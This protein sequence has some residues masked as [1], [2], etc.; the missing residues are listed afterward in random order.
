MRNQL[1]TFAPDG[2]EHGAIY[3]SPINQNYQ[4]QMAKSLVASMGPSNAVGFALD[5]SWD[6]VLAQIKTLVSIDGLA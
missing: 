3:K 1:N 2:H 6:G 4:R 5:N